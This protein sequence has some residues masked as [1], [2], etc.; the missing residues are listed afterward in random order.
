MTRWVADQG[1]PTAR[2]GEGGLSWKGAVYQLRLE[3]RRLVSASDLLV[4]EWREA[5]DAVE[6]LRKVASGQ[7]GQSSAESELDSYFE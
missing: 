4:L 7:K 5:L 6:E 1:E 2:Q 3:D